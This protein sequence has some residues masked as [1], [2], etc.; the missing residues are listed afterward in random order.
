MDGA[1]KTWSVCGLKRVCGHWALE[2]YV[3]GALY[4]WTSAHFAACLRYWEIWGAILLFPCSV[5]S[6]LEKDREMHSYVSSWYF[7]SRCTKAGRVPSSTVMLS[8]LVF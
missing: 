1:V 7:R 4:G 8:V 3:S 6:V 5:A 2:P